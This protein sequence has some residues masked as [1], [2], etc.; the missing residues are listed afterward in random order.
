M[1]RYRNYA[2]EDDTNLRLRCC[3]LRLT[4]SSPPGTL[5]CPMCAYFIGRYYISPSAATSSPLEMLYASY[6]A[7][8]A[9]RRVAHAFEAPAH[10]V[11]MGCMRVSA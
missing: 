7:R 6:P 8:G 11:G 5:V 3:L 10:R 4:P 2:A 9:L 1:F